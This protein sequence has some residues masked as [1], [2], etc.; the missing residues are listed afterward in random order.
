MTPH[1]FNGLETMEDYSSENGLNVTHI[2]KKQFRVSPNKQ[3]KKIDL[4]YEVSKPIEV[5]ERTYQNDLM[6]I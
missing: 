5:P 4:F 6:Q 2:L 3:Q 1:Y